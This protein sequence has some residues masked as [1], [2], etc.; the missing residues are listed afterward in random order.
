MNLF[1]MAGMGVF[2]GY[3]LTYIAFEIV[4]RGK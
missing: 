3:M 1:E 4:V 2:I